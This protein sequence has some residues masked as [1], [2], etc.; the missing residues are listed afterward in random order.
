M[1]RITLGNIA[2][3]FSIYS[4]WQPLS[5]TKFCAFT[6]DSVQTLIHSVRKKI[7]FAKS[8][9]QRIDKFIFPDQIRAIKR[10]QE[11]PHK[12]ALCDLVWS[13]PEDVGKTLIN[14]ISLNCKKIGENNQM[15]Y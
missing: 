11:I 13:D 8:K 3:E 9:I 14:I 4:Q 7:I 12:G 15:K 5:T 2:P 10:D 1:V 6:A